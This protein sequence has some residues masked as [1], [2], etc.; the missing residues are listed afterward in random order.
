MASRSKLAALVAATGIAW[1]SGSAHAWH[2]QGH[3]MVAAV[4]WEQMTDAVRARAI[5]P[6]R[7]NK[8]YDK[9]IS[10]VPDNLKDKTAFMRASV[11]PDDIKN[12][13]T[14]A[15]FKN[16]GDTPP[17]TKQAG[18]NIGYA[19][20]RMHKYWHYKDIPFSPDGTKTFPAPTPNA[21][22]Q[23]RRFTAAISKP[24]VNDNIK[25][26][27]IVWLIH[28]VGDVHQP[29]HATSRFTKAFKTSEGDRGGN[30]VRIDCCGSKLHTYWDGVVGDSRDPKDAA[31]AA[32]TLP[33]APAAAAAISDPG[34]WILE[35]FKVA[36]AEVYKKP[37]IEVIDVVSS[38][39]PAYK[40]D[41]ERIAR[42]RVALAGA[43][44]ARLFNDN[45]K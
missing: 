44:L 31:A 6:L 36:K 30:S 27:D 19:D 12:P 1:S 16:D 40:A 10:G 17:K 26:Y 45:L 42:E 2:E 29:L 35:S 3:M 32:A 22:T 24:N 13:F 5:Q 39:T 34:A 20:K 25:S 23:I 43:R 15:G 33:A 8:D 4:A 18:Q 7:I 41:A 37:P 14:H 38:L 11:W 28:M 9:W 21:E